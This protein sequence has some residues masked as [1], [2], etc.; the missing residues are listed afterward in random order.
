L[1]KAVFIGSKSTYDFLRKNVKPNWDWQIPVATIDEFWDDIDNDRLDGDHT[2]VI[3]ISTEFYRAAVKKKDPALLESFLDLIFSSTQTAFTMI[4]DYFNDSADIER[5]LLKYSG[6]EDNQ[7]AGVLKSYWWIDPRKPNPTIDSAIRE[8]INSPDSEPDIVKAVAEA[9]NMP[10]S[11]VKND[12]YEDDQEEQEKREEWFGDSLSEE[13]PEEQYSNNYGKK[14]EIICT[15]GSK[16]GVGKTTTAMGL[17]AWIA[18]SS[19]QAAAAGTLKAPLKVCIVDFDV[20]DAQI[21][22]MIGK[23]TPNILQIAIAE[24][25]N[26]DVVGK[27]V[28]YSDRMKCSFLLSPKL[29][30]SADNIPVSK[31]DEIISVLQYMFDVIIIDTSVNYKDKLFSVVTYPR[32][33]R[34]IFV[35]SLDRKSVIGMM[36]WIYYNGSSQESGGTEIDLSKV[37]VVVNMAQHDVNMTSGEIMSIINMATQRA[38]STLDRSIRPEDWHTPKLI[39]A[40]PV[41]KNGLLV[42]LSNVLQF[43]LSMGIPF[44]EEP[45]SQIA[46]AVLPEA[47]SKVLNPIK[48][49][50]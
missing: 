9:E 18:M 10:I 21:G 22:S 8:Y 1:L 49:P 7:E 14:A 40:I 33:D 46:K 11:T 26:Q 31:F 42:K 20:N 27:N 23:T 41:I 32:A 2:V 4:V 5:D 3:V 17:G 47:F 39:G 24:D 13:G 44:F 43:D 12:D 30:K 6:R 50:E 45:I 25:I 35:T 16:G 48:T 28:I 34:I 36:K 29:P 38:Y 37:G 15:T 19:E